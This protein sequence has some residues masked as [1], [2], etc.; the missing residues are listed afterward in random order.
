MQV[1]KAPLRDMQFVLHELHDSDSLSKLPGFE[2][3]TPELFDSVLEE[4]AKFVEQVLLPL[5]MSGDEEGCRLENGVVRTPNGFREAYAQYREAGWTA[6]GS[7]PQFGGQGLPESIGKLV[8]EMVCAANVSFALYPGLSFGAYRA[9]SAHGTKEQQEL[10][11]PK[12]VDG[13]WSG[14]MCLT[15]AH[16]GTDLGLVRTRAVPQ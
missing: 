7:D 2:E 13:T 5:N 14:T 16:C 11:L 6:L 15:E 1:Y 9:I 4:A 3:M 12:L 10:Y 8:E